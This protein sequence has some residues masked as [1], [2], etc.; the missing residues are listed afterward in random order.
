MDLSVNMHAFLWRDGQMLDLGS[1]PGQRY[2]QANAINDLGW[3]VGETWDEIGPDAASRAF[4][5]RDGEMIDL[6]GLDEAPV[7]RALAVSNTGLIV[8]VS[9]N[10]AF[11]WSD[12]TMR[13]L[14]DENS[15][16]NSVNN[17]GQIAGMTETHA[18][19]WT[20]SDGAALDLGV[21]PGKSFSAAYA[22]NAAGQIAGNGALWQDGR[23]MPVGDWT[24]TSINGSKLVVGWSHDTADHPV[25]WQEQQMF[26]LST[27][28]TGDTPSRVA[29]ALAINDAGQIVGY[30]FRQSDPGGIQRAVL[31]TPLF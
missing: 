17:A 14:T 13:A 26:D 29:R 31:L 12:G 7:T 19:Q 27:L 10:R 28:L 18:V 8:G 15:V 6:G 2:S 21:P 3:V 20:A 16:A 11:V 25:L 24:P 1:L 22:I 9:G 5:W 4:L 23:W 30:G